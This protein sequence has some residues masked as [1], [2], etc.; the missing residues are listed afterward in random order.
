M[1]I[2]KITSVKF[3]Y[4]LK[5]KKE[6]IKYLFTNINTNKSILILLLFVYLLLFNNLSHK[7]VP[8]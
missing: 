4:I 1:I 7:N 3:N 2:M 6:I 8:I 5:T